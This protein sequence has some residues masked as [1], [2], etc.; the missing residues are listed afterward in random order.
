[1]STTLLSDVDRA[2]LNV[3]VANGTDLTGIAGET[4]I[5]LVNA[6]YT[7]SVAVDALSLTASTVVY[8]RPGFNE[9]AV[10][11]AAELELSDSR[12]Q[13]LPADAVTGQDQL[14]DV[15]VVIGTDFPR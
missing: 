5:A 9:A 10:S 8:Y 2:A 4:A 1:V 7:K 3:I 15:I 12:V 6:G 11:V 13:A 14:G